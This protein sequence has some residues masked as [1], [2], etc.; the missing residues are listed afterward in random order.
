MKSNLYKYIEFFISFVLLPVSFTLNFPLWIKITLG[1]LGFVYVVFV[2]LK[3]ENNQFKISENLNWK[4]FWKQTFIRF[5]LIALATIVFVWMVDNANLFQVVINKPKLWVFIIFTYSVFSVYP[6]ELIFRTFYFQRYKGL[7]KNESLFIFLNA[8]VFSL[9]HLFYGNALVNLITFLGGLLFAITFNKT[10][11]TL[12]VSIEH[13]I[14]GC[15]LFTV[16]MGDMLGF[17]H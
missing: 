4:Q 16:G 1:L 13:I 11:S 5:V 17:P 8:I 7:F 9:A 14:Y 15:W 6:Q 12:L 3:I 2:L 10:Q